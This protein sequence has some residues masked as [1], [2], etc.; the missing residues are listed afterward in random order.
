[1]ADTGVLYNTV[2]PGAKIVAR[3]KLNVRVSLQNIGD[4]DITVDR[5]RILAWY[6][7]SRFGKSIA[8][9]D[10][11]DGYGWITLT[12]NN[13][14]RSDFFLGMPSATGQIVT[15]VDVTAPLPPYVLLGDINMFVNAKIPAGQTVTQEAE[16]TNLSLW[17][18]YVNVKSDRPGNA[19]AGLVLSYLKGEQTPDV[20][21]R[22][23]IT[24]EQNQD[25]VVFRIRGIVYVDKVP[26]VDTAVESGILGQ[27]KA[28]LK[29]SITPIVSAPEQVTVSTP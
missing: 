22:F 29:I 2:R 16:A 11:I 28:P 14:S 12:D 1:M 19:I 15:K 9:Y 17:I 20:L 23:G 25:P 24:L 8:S 27:L 21:E 4:K 7:L 6:D 3:G 5:V 18:P 13:P 10:E 26:V